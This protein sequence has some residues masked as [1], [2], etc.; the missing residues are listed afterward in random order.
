MQGFGNSHAKK[1]T[2]IAAV[3]IKV[4]IATANF[5]PSLNPELVLLPPPTPAVVVGEELGALEIV[6]AVVVEG[7]WASDEGFAVAVKE[8]GVFGAVNTVTVE[9]DG[10]SEIADKVV[11]EEEKVLGTINRVVVEE[12][13]LEIAES[14]IVER[15]RS[16]AMQ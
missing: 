15:G 13:V 8:G 3:P 12:G 14:V 2:R 10:V 5:P 4:E 9:E 6:C 7:E 11:F 16:W 1:A